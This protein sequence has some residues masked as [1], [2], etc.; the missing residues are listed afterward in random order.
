MHFC[1]QFLRTFSASVR[2]AFCCRTSFVFASGT[3]DRRMTW[4]SRPLLAVATFGGAAVF[5]KVMAHV[6]RHWR[7]VK[8]K[9]DA[10]MM[11]DSA[12][13]GNASFWLVLH[14]VSAVFGLGVAGLTVV[15]YVVCCMM[16]VYMS[17]RTSFSGLFDRGSQRNHLILSSE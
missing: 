3:V 14:I 12:F 6:F 2:C 7:S 4:F 16:F 10:E 8:T 15:M 1:C 9:F 11:E 5:A 13:Y 17:T